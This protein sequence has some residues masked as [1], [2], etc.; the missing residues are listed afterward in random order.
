[1]TDLQKEVN[2]AFMIISSIPVT[3]DSVDRM[4]MAREHLR[5]AYQMA[6]ESKE[7]KDDGG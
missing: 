7:E 5:R 1:M 4:A 2:E 3:G 6:E